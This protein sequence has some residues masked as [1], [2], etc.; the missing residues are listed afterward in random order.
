VAKLRDEESGSELGFQML[1]C[2]QVKGRREYSELGLQVPGCGQVKG[3]RGWP[4][5]RSSGARLWPS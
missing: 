3:R 2:G 5:A 4:R 1:G